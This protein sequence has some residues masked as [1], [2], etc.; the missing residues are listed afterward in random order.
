MPEW[1]DEFGAPHNRP[2]IVQGLQIRDLAVQQ[3]RHAQSQAATLLVVWNE[4]LGITV[5]TT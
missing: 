1:L 2:V 3:D 4:Y 5:F